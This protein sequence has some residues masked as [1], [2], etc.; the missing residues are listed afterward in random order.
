MD[1]LHK[2]DS[3]WLLHLNPGDKVMIYQPRSMPINELV[4]IE[5]IIKNLLINDAYYT[6]ISVN[7]NGEILDYHLIGLHTASEFILKDLI[8][9]LDSNAENLKDFKFLDLSTNSLI[10][11][12]IIKN[13]PFYKK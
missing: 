2:K 8:S 1:I 7:S 11:N 6:K 10:F 5:S 13:K 3:N 4:L 12:Q 9:G